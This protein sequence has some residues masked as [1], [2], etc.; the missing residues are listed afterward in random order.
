MTGRND[1]FPIT[2]PITAAGKEP[3]VKRTIGINKMYT[4]E[5]VDITNISN[6]KPIAKPN[7]TFFA[8]PGDRKSLMRFNLILRINKSEA[9]RS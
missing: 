2:L 1:S 8:P 4:R 3:F 5:A 7:D 6:P 9:K